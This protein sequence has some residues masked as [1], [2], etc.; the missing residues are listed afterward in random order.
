MAFV[1]VVG[2]SEIYNFCIQS[3]V[4]FYSNFWS[5]SCSNGGSENKTGWPHSA[6]RRHAVTPRPCA[7]RGRAASLGRHVP[8]DTQESAPRHTPARHPRRTGRTRTA[9]PSGPSAASPPSCAVLR[10]EPSRRHHRRSNPA[11]FK[12][13][14]FSSCPHRRSTAPPWPP[15]R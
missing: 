10:L 15:S 8:R 14:T 12:A 4:H 7:A 3:F 6:L 2:G 13:P 5:Y 1:K 9:R 11:L